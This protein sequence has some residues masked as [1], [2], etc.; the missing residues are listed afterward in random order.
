MTFAPGET[1]KTVT[2]VVLGDT[3]PEANETFVLSLTSVS[4]GEV[5]DGLGVGT[6]RDD[7]TKGKPNRASVPQQSSLYLAE[8]VESGGA[9]TTTAASQDQSGPRGPAVVFSRISLP[10]ET[11]RADGRAAFLRVTS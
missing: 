4:G 11:E 3:T 10:P 1:S 7:D 2:V 5:G 6:I 9:G 8:A